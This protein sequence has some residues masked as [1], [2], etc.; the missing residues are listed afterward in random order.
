MSMCVFICVCPVQ[1]VHAGRQKH[2]DT[3]TET[4]R[5]GLKEKQDRRCVAAEKTRSCKNSRIVY[6]CLCGGIIAF[7]SFITSQVFCSSQLI[8]QQ[9]V[10]ALQG[11]MKHA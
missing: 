8:V 10:L 7:Y 6:L 1:L 2:T 3:H 9:V 4:E 11:A 5:D